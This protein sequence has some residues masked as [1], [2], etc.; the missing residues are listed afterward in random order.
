LTRERGHW[1]DFLPLCVATLAPHP[2]V[3][4]DLPGNGV[5]HH[6]TS[7]TNIHAMVQA[8]RD[9]LAQQGHAPPYRVLAVSMGGM[10]AVA[11]AHLHPHE[12]SHMV[13]INTSMRPWNPLTQRLRPRHWATLLR[14]LATRSSALAWETAIWRMTSR[15]SA[16]EVIQGWLL[17]REQHPVSARNALRQLWAAARFFAPTHRPTPHTLLLA[18]SQDDLVAVQCSRTL[19]GQWGL[20]LAEHPGAGHDLTLDD[21]PW[22]LERIQAW[23]NTT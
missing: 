18:S 5:H 13:L 16:P 21:G 6:Q 15:L 22:V 7:P 12:V 10:V 14:L 17:L 2:V 19:A 11:W 4:L 20:P 8:C 9:Q 1:G 3:A 23:L